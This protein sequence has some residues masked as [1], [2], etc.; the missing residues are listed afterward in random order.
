M[1]MLTIK[2]N[3]EESKL[4][5][6]VIGRVDTTTAPQLDNEVSQSLE[7]ITELVLDFEQT[8][9]VSSAGLRVLLALY[10]TMNA[11][12]G[13]LVLCKVNHTIV[14]MFVAT[15]LIDFFEIV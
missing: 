14:E 7:G 3:Q 13:R 11:K 10:K 5:V 2:K 6:T 4:T 8:E 12:Q 9:Y 1:S 15:G